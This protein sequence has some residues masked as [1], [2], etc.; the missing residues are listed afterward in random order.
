MMVPEIVPPTIS[1]ETPADVMVRENLNVTLKCIAKGYPHPTIKWRREDGRP[2]E[3]GNWQEK[4]TA[5]IDPREFD[6]F[7]HEWAHLHNMKL[8]FWRKHADLNWLISSPERFSEF[9]TDRSKRHRFVTTISDR[10]PPAKTYEGESLLIAKVSRLHMGA[11]LAIGEYI[12]S[13]TLLL[14]RGL[15]CRQI[16]MNHHPPVRM[17]QHLAASS[18]KPGNDC[19]QRVRMNMHEKEG[20]QFSGSQKSPWLFWIEY[21]ITRR[22]LKSRRL[23]GLAS[24][25]LYSGRE[26]YAC[27]NYVIIGCDHNSRGVETAGNCNHAAILLPLRCIN[28]NP[29]PLFYAFLLIFSAEFMAA[30]LSCLI[31]YCYPSYVT[32]SPTADDHHHHPDATNHQPRMVFHHPFPRGSS[33]MFIVSNRILSSSRTRC[34]IEPSSWFGWSFYSIIPLFH[35]PPLVSGFPSILSNDENIQLLPKQSKWHRLTVIP[36][37]TI[38]W[39][40]M[41]IPE[42]SHSLIEY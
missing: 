12:F 15:S 42:W 1:P 30:Q 35:S 29:P 7:L 33:S 38:V 3:H 5:G 11:Y 23:S 20:I 28:E 27:H 25:S 16:I 4:K 10:R 32:S 18:G 17:L 39:I 21:S 9:F 8:P 31:G 22:R 36:I 19:D 14:F 24:D 40:E 13:M 2:I 37:L 26:Y 6:T 41:T 34:M